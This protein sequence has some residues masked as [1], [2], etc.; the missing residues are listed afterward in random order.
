M[1]QVKTYS[2]QKPIFNLSHTTNDKDVFLSPWPIWLTNNFAA[3][4]FNN[5]IIN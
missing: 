4:N 2:P 1:L 3:Y 5:N